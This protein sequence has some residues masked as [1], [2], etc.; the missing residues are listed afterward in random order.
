MKNTNA[1]TLSILKNLI[2][3]PSW[4]D[5]TSNESQIGEWIFDY[6]N[7]NTNLSVT[8][9]LIDGDRFNIVATNSKITDTL[10]IGHIDTVQPN[11]NWTI[12]P[13]RS[14]VVSGKLFGLGA[15]D[16][17][18]G[19]ALMLYLSGLSTLKENTTFL[20]YCD[21]EYDFTG[22]KSFIPK[23]KNKMQP[24][25]ILSLDGDGLQIGNSCRGLIEIKVTVEGK[26]GHAA[27]PISGVNAIT[28]S[29]KVIDSVRRM[30]SKY[31]TKELGNSTLNIAFIQGGTKKESKD[32][33]I[34]LGQQGNIIAN[35]CEYILEIRVASQKL[36]ATLV[37][38][39]I[40]TESKKLSLKVNSIDTRHD[41]GSWITPKI[42]LE[43]Y[44]KM[45]PSNI[46]KSAKETG[47]LDIQML[48]K[49]FGKIPTFSF[50]AGL[51]GQAHKSD[52][53]VKISDIIK[54]QKFLTRILTNK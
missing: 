44:I 10:I 17:K 9:Q 3:I 42:Q 26:A 46:L 1:E 39:F 34:I 52:E 11:A 22:M 50:G 21:E 13:T 25:L 14:E 5:S 37:K 43:K 27:R 54:S 12:N 18:C 38:N 48:W 33:Q 31:S 53:Y 4:V 15:S 51:I 29:Q 20:F 35:Y 32:G 23:Y 45:A 24:K 19:I 7:K 40:E 30:L 16:M 6:L 2:S 49:A 41:L 36:D 28:E 8:K 47:Y